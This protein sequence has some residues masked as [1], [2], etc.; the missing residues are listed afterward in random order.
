LLRQFLDQQGAAA[1]QITG[2]LAGNDAPLAERLA[3]TVKGVAGSLGAGRVQ[4]VAAKLEKA[5]VAKY[6]STELDPI[7]HDFRTTLDDFGTR[8]RAALPQPEA[9]PTPEALAAPLDLERAKPVVEEMLSHLNNFDPAAGECLEA[10]RGVFH[11]LLSAEAF[12]RF[13]QHINGFAFG[14]A[15]A[16]LQPAAKGKGLI[17][18]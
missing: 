14:D 16:Q 3:H 15:L 10:N 5:I 7:L 13:E 18:S 4:Q 9:V 17:T 1:A 11:A 2:A 6:S 8:L 12:A